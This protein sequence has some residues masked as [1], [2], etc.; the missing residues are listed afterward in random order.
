MKIDQPT[1]IYLHKTVQTLLACKI[2]NLIIEPGHVRA[3][4]ENRAV[5]VFQ[6]TDVPDMPFKSIG[7][8]EANA[9]MSRF[10]IAKSVSDVEINAIMDPTDT[11]VRSLEMRGKG[12][13]IDFRCANPATIRAPKSMKDPIK[14][15][16]RMTGD[17]VNL[18]AKGA[19]A[20]ST[21]EVTLTGTNTSVSLSFED[22]N[23]DALTYQFGTETELLDGST[24]D[25]AFERSYPNKILL[26]L[27]KQ[28]PDTYLTIT[29]NGLIKMSVNGLDVYVP[30]RT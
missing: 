2:N 19:A 12:I 17:A 13:K 22:A 23:R 18:M 21:D 16:I 3:M 7:I 4:E 27:L 24:D 9:F 6:D 1:L 5:L 29:Q 8:S 28:N 30:P 11:F 15:K 14:Y 10:E 25:I 20:L 26:P